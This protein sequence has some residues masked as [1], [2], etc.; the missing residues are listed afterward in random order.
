MSN[1]E[2]KW[3]IRVQETCCFSARRIFDYWSS[4]VSPERAYRLAVAAFSNN[5]EYERLKR[6]L[7]YR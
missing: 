2:A 1:E 6:E 5:R 7:G 3:R 4:S